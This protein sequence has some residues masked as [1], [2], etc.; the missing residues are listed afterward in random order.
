MLI[1][2]WFSLQSFPQLS[3]WLCQWFV[4]Y[5]RLGPLSVATDGSVSSSSKFN[6]SS[7]SQ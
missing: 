1:H 4:S 6:V 7:V 3:W 5:C 2:R